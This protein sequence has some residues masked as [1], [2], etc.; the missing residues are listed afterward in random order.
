V[1][2][3]GCWLERIT[4]IASNQ[5]RSQLVYT[6][7]GDW[8]GVPTI[9]G[10]VLVQSVPV[11]HGLVAVDIANANKPTEVSRLKLDDTCFSHW[12][13]WDAKTQRMV[14]T[15]CESRLYL[16]KMDQT[17]GA[18]TIDDAFH[19]AN[20]K[21]GFNFANRDWQHGWKGSG[22]PHGVVFSR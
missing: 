6:F 16:V 9:V 7:P 18:L 5:P 15:G 1:Q 8:C 19:D 4:G 2:T 12:T 21:P 20:G 17:T 14:V 13:G 3:L 22:K 11:I 10:H